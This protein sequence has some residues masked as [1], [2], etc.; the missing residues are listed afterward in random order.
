VRACGVWT[1]SVLLSGQSSFISLLPRIIL[2]HVDWQDVEH[3]EPPATSNK[4]VNG[5][6]EVGN[7]ST[8]K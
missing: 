8:L 7:V 2:M 1:W 6:I 3:N 4:L 5:L